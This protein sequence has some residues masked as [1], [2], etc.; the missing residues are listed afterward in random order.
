MPHN[1]AKLF[2]PA[3]IAIVGASQDPKKIGHI[4]LKNIFNSG[5]RGKIFP[6]NPKVDKI[7]GLKCYAD[8]KFLPEIPDL[9]IIAVPAEVA[10]KV[11]ESIGKKGTKNVIVYSSGFKEAGSEGEKMEESLKA[12]AKKFELNIL[13]PNCLGFVN[14]ARNLNA[15]FSKASRVVGNVNFIS[16]S[17]ALASAIFDWSQKNQIGFSEFITLGNKAVIN[18]NDILKYWINK[19]EKNKPIGMYLESIADGREFLNLTKEISVHSPI[20]ILKPGQSPGA[21]RAMRSHTGAM[22]ADD[23]VQGAALKEAGVIRCDG[24]EDLFDLM[25]LFSWSKAPRGP[26]VAVVSN[27]GGPAV[28]SA[29]AIKKEGLN[30][31]DFSEAA[32]KKLQSKL[33]PASAVA[34]PVDVLGDAL[35]DRYADAMEIVLSE[36]NVDAL[37]VVLTPQVMTEIEE[38]A[39][40][41]ARLSA[42]HDKPVICSFMGGGLIER[43]EDVLNAYKIPSFRFPERAIWALARMWEWSVSQKAKGKR[44]KF[45]NERR[46]PSSLPLE[47]GGR[48][49]LSLL[50]ANKILESAGIK[51]PK[52]KEVK[53][54]E[55]AES[56]AQANG[57]PVV[58]KISSA[59]MLHK[60]E[61]GGVIVN[62]DNPGQLKIA[63]ERLEEKIKKARNQK[64]NLAKIVAQKQVI[65]GVEVI[66]GV[67]RDKNFGNVLLFG[68]GGILAELIADKNLKLLPLDLKS[69]KELISKSRV[70][71]LLN[72]Y[73]GKKPMAIEKLANLMVKLSALAEANNKISE[74]EINP[75]IVTEKEAWAVDGRVIIES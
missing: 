13:G 17:G 65:G 58:L 68:A 11:L 38:T 25:K 56:F 41:I 28:I 69:A 45:V 49:A 26:N 6:V 31:A 33:P 1:L 18:E 30:L 71:K 7:G 19:K 35:A 20:F 23:A 5:F 59:K 53:N 55:E 46:T 2:H 39:E 50:E 73:R 60:T 54:L 63:F 21:Q 8:V 52:T 48:Q 43:G 62:L 32:R 22:A 36:N 27:A 61:G 9:A 42:H 40:T 37:L 29:D 34:N 10:L 4:V 14:N 12:I 75:V 74:I 70:F 3:S 64:N 44:Q 72:G 51:V 66:V 15:T 57:W 47:K 24:V 67:K 16:Q